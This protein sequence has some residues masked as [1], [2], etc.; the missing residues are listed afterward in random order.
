MELNDAL[1]TQQSYLKIGNYSNTYLLETAVQEIQG[2]LL[3]NPEVIIYGKVAHQHRSIG[4]FSNE[5]VGYSYSGKI[6]QSQPLTPS[7]EIL[8]ENIN[9][10]FNSNYNGI[11]V[12]YYSNGSDY[13]G[14]HSDDETMLGP[15]GVISLSYGATRKFRIRDKNTKKIVIDVP[16]TSGTLIWMGGKFQREFTHEIPAEKKIKEGRYSFTFRQHLL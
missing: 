11:L 14:A 9:S 13:I 3:T 6:A 8:L 1:T 15:N 4:F 16:V 5:S 10:I 7:L 12:N 2:L